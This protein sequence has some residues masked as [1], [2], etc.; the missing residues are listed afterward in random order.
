MHNEISSEFRQLEIAPALAAIERLQRDRAYRDS[1]GLFFV[2]GVRNFIEALD[3]RF[4]VDTLLYSEKL[5]IHPL[6]RKLVRRLK[7]AG[8]PFARVT[9]EQFRRVSKTERASGVAVDSSPTS[10]ETRSNQAHR[11]RVLDGAA[12]SPFARELRYASA[13]VCRNRCGRIHPPGRQHRLLRSGCSPGNDGSA[14]QA[15]DCAND[16]RAAPAMGTRAQHPSHRGLAR[17]LGRLSPGELTRP[18]L[19][20]LGGERK[21]LT[22]EQRSM[23][24]RIV[25]I[26]MVEGM[27]SLNVAV[28]GSLLMYEV[29][30]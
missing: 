6:A 11:S 15:D 23:C 5:L 28:A 9:P 17:R 26:P 7:R 24:D 22:D 25:R 16:Y 8:V 2:E 19:L 20:M 12:P 13:N 21:G 30:R 18:A 3:Q 14:L 29:F 27:D 1:R 4:S 10:T